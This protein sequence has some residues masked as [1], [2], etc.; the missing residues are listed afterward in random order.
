MSELSASPVASVRGSFARCCRNA[1]FIDNFYHR[2]A[3]E[4]PAVGPMFAETDMRTQDTLIRAGISH[5][6]DF[7]DRVDGVRSKID[8]LGV[9]HNRHHLDVKPE[10]YESWIEALIQAAAECD[11]FFDEQ[12]ES[13]WREVLRPGIELMASAYSG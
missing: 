11:D 10:L 1:D 4:A 12:V 3:N 7:A 9:K 6:I 5:L 13:A 2:L 8:E